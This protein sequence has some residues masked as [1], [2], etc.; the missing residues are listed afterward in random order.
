MKTSFLIKYY[1]KLDSI[2]SIDCCVA[3]QRNKIKTTKILH[4]RLE[5]L[6]GFFLMCSAVYHKIS[7]M[8]VKI[9]QMVFTFVM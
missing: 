5:W 7:A 3:V 4:F 1:V 8:Q 9:I 6:C 2:V